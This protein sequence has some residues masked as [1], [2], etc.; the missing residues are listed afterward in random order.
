M[1]RA[2]RRLRH[3]R[4]RLGSHPQSWG[5]PLPPPGMHHTTYMRLVQEIVAR[6][7][8]ILSLAALDLM[9]LEASVARLDER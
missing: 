4:T 3:L 8:T 9:A 6:E 2:H 1:A 7:H 5:I